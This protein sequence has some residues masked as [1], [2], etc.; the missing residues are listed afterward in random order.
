MSQSDITLFTSIPPRMSR[1]VQGRD[2]GRSWQTACVKSWNDAGFRV[3]SLNP[4]E[5]IDGLRKSASSV[6]FLPIPEGIQRPRTWDFFEAAKASRSKVAGIINA[7]CMILPQA[8]IIEH[9]R[10]DIDGVVIAERLNLSNKNFVPTGSSCFGF[11]A[12]FFDVAA[13]EFLEKDEHWRIGEVWVDYW[14]PLA[15]H[16]AGF[17]IKTMPAPVLL[18]L[19]HD[20][21]WDLVKWERHFPKLVDFVRRHGGLR[22]DKR[23]S[24]ELLRSR[25]LNRQEVTT[26]QHL[27][28]NWL[29]SHEPLWRPEP[30]TLDD[31]TTSLLCSFATPKMSRYEAFRS[32]M[33]QFVD[34]FGLRR[35][36]HA[37]GLVKRRVTL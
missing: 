2:F 20:I 17:S 10:T 16:L 13:L 7:D 34:A 9:L 22:S 1:I 19:D 23:V 14:I 33:R 11:D 3:V 5:E 15:F 21:A 26:L 24:D 30:G 29:R 35:P 28:F 37:L 27:L 4:P 18:H 32:S 31:L 12:F 25:T 6:K 8:G 36:L